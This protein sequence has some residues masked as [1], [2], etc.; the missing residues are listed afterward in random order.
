MTVK[1]RI[2]G[3][4][5][6]VSLLY[7]I[8]S[9]IA[10]YYQSSATT[11]WSFSFKVILLATNLLLFLTYWLSLRTIKSIDENR[12]LKIIYIFSFVFCLIMIITPP[13][14]SADVY[15]YAYRARVQT[16]YQENPYIV[17]TGEYPDDMFYNFSPK[18][19][20]YLTM[21][22]GPFWT[23]ISIF[24][25]EITRGSFFWNIFLYKILALVSF[26]GSA[27]LVNKILKD[28][29]SKI[30]VPSM[31]LYL[32]SPIVVFEAVNN[33]HNDMFM[34]FLLI[35]G[36]YLLKK[37]WYLLSMIVLLLSILVKYISLLIVP[38]FLIYIFKTVNNSKKRSK[39]LVQCG[40]LSIAFI[41]LF[42]LPFWDGLEIFRGL[43]EQSKINTY[44]N[45]SLLPAV[46][47]WIIHVVTTGFPISIE[48]IS[49]IA[50]V[51][52]F[53]FFILGYLWVI[54]SYIK[55]KAETFLEYC[56]MTILIYVFFYL[57]Y[58]QPWYLVWVIPLAII[59]ERK[60]SSQF[61]FLCTLAG[62]L[63]YNIIMNSLI[64]VSIFA[65]IILVSLVSR[66][67]YIMKFVNK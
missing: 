61:I 20:N 13:I 52:G 59:T 49:K 33:A 34:V 16:V 67:N 57:S 32:W 58:L 3:L 2:I 50:R 21:Q 39:I 38:I 35:L 17:A 31:L 24:F 23:S 62:L 42:Y 55:N 28:N 63:S 30:I 60:Y 11:P 65:I 14:G 5:V 46:V 29:K 47:Y 10:F 7:S 54:K 53:I 40:I 41:I 12:I 66:K 26:F 64:Y 25:S 43:W 48:T 27:V 45:F 51:F 18:E 9:F 36:I 15:N 6:G 4:G 22:Y 19:W 56:F 44:A 37:K 1:N 8:F